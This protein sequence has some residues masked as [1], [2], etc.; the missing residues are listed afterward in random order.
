M[1]PR[2]LCNTPIGIW[3]AAALA[4]SRALRAL[5]Q[6]HGH[7]PTVTPLVLEPVTADTMRQARYRNN[8]GAR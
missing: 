7:W 8:R 5:L 1:R 6:A 2:K 4:E 3:R